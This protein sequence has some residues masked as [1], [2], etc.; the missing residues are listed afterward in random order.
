MLYEVIT[1]LE[2]GEIDL[3]PSI[4]FTEERAKKLTFSREPVISDW[5]QVFVPKDSPIHSIID[6]DG[7]VV[8]VMKDSVFFSGPRITS[9]NVCYTK[10]LRFGANTGVIVAGELILWV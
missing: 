8:A 3:L 1:R 2:Q 7:R 4:A 9:Y 5:G 6:L 10:L